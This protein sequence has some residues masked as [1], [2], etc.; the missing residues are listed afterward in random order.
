MF[1]SAIIL[2]VTCLMRFSLA[3]VAETENIPP[4]ATNTYVTSQ[5]LNCTKIL[6]EDG[7][8]EKLDN[9]SVYVE[10]YNKMYQIM[11]YE[12]HSEGILL[13]HFTQEHD[14]FSLTL[15]FLTFVGLCSSCI[16]ITLHLIA[17]TFVP[18]FKRNLM[19]KNL[20]ALCVVLL[21]S[22]ATFVIGNIIEYGTVGCFVLAAAMYYFFLSSFCWMNIMAFNILRS[23]QMSKEELEQYQKGKFCK[24]LSIIYGYFAP[25]V[26]LSIVVILDMIEPEGIPTHLLPSLGQRLCWFEKR[27]ALTAFFAAP[28]GM[29][30]FINFII[31]ILSFIKIND[32]TDQSTRKARRKFIMKNIALAVLIGLPWASGYVAGLSHWDLLWLIFV[33]LN[34]LQGTFVFIFFTPKRKLW[35]VLTCRTCSPSIKSIYVNGN[36]SVSNK[37][38][39]TSINSNITV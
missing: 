38:A 7:D 33:L 12:Y 36:P 37:T 34:T 16:S 8:F 22:Y 27:S 4:M 15:V 26:V 25:L 28:L 3:V 21:A 31:F 30:M 5:S 9:G 32:I 1:A 18:D 6:L 13:C 24:I 20:I 39:T 14:T 2:L 10:A 35:E 23:L 17:F 19:G 11:D 29:L